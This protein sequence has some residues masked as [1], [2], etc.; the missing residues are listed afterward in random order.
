MSIAL[1]INIAAMH[2]HTEHIK[3]YA[4]YTPSHEQLFHDWLLRSVQEFGE[5]ELIAECHAQE[6]PSGDF[7]QD[8]WVKTMERKVDL[9]IKAIHDNWGDIFIHADVDIQF[10]DYCA[11]LIKHEMCNV[12][13]AFQRENPAGGLCGGFFVCRANEKTLALFEQ[14]KKIMCSERNDQICL[15]DLLRFSNPFN[16]AWKY[17][18]ECFFG[19]ATLKSDGWS[20]AWTPQAGEIPMPQ[21]PVMHHANFTVGLQNKNAQLS[22]VKTRAEKIKKMMQQK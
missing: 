15:N 17:L 21:N 2:A 3:I 6:C 16:I 11:D 19:G 4:I 7:M 10:L 9:V 12:D 14:V 22:Q 20:P 1:I 5:F 13:L 18:P 8:G